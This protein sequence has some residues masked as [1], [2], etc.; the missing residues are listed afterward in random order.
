MVI[1]S[2]IISISCDCQIRWLLYCCDLGL[3]ASVSETERCRGCAMYFNLGLAVVFVTRIEVA[4][5]QFLC[6]AELFLLIN[7]CLLSLD[8]SENW[9]KSV[10]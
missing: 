8:A 2:V 9:T 6:I 10:F 1:N 3:T 4:I 7:A 5:S